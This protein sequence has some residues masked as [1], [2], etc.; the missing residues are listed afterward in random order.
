LDILF[1]LFGKK[2]EGLVVIEEIVDGFTDELV[3]NAE[4]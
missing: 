3:V 1:F 2:F 4:E